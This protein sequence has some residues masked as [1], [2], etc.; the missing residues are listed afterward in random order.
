MYDVGRQMSCQGLLDSCDH[1]SSE[2]AAQL[3]DGT[4]DVPHSSIK[5]DISFARNWLSPKD[6]MIVK[7]NAPYSAAVHDNGSFDF[8]LDVK[9]VNVLL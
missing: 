2:Y 7:I 4:N 6:P 1:W 3:R 8:L 9:V 5:F